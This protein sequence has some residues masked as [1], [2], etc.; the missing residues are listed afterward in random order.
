L[1]IEIIGFLWVALVA[2]LLL[3]TDWQHRARPVEWFASH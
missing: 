3:K 1:P 2:A